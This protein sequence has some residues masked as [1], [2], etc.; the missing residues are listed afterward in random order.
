MAC[1]KF[2]PVRNI[3]KW[4]FPSQSDKEI[5]CMVS[6]CLNSISRL[7]PG[8][9]L[10]GTAFTGSSQPALSLN[11]SDGKCCEHAQKQCQPEGPLSERLFCE[12]GGN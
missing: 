7:F 9:C 8:T 2:Q 11:G 12:S 10:P 3:I 4:R 6:I 5:N 1:S